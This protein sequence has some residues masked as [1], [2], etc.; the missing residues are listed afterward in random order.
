MYLVRIYG[1]ETEWKPDIVSVI[2]LL[3]DLYGLSITNVYD[4]L[5]TQIE[6]MTNTTGRISHPDM[7]LTIEYFDRMRFNM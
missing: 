5:Y 6:N 7:G 1:F 2:R 3:C 4:K